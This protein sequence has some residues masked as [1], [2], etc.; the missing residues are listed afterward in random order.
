M[1]DLRCLC[2]IGVFR[3]SFGRGFSLLK[4]GLELFD[5]GVLFF[6][7]LLQAF[8]SIRHRS[9]SILEVDCES[10]LMRLRR[11]MTS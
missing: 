9:P 2:C 10:V 6:D 8:I 7:V 11:G 4:A 1:T 3:L 5:T